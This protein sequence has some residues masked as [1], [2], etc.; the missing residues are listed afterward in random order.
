MTSFRCQVAGQ[1]QFTP[2]SIF[3][4]AGQTILALE[5][6]TQSTRNKNILFYH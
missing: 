3:I 5:F 6:V 1:Q 2:S 4:T